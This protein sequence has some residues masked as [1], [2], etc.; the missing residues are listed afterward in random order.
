MKKVIYVFNSAFRPLYLANVLNTLFLPNGSTNEYRY[1]IQNVSPT[2]EETLKPKLPVSIIYIDRFNVGGYC[3][4]PLRLGH[5]VS[6]QIK[7]DRF[8]IKVKLADFVFPKDQNVFGKYTSNLQQQ[9]APMLTNNDPT[10]FKDGYYAF[11]YND[12]FENKDEYLWGDA[13]WDVIIE[14]LSK[15]KAFNLGLAKPVVYLSASIKGGNGKILSP[16]LGRDQ[17]ATFDVVRNKRYTLDLF[18]RFPLQRENTEVIE[19]LEVD[20][21][22][23]FRL[24]DSEVLPINSSSNSVSKLFTT[25]KYPNDSYGKISIKSNKDNVIISDAIIHLRIRETGGYWVEVFF[26]A[27]VFLVCSVLIGLNLS[28]LKYVGISIDN[29]ENGLTTFQ[30]ILESIKHLLFFI[31]TALIQGISVFRM[32]KLLGKNII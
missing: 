12:I 30:V 32:F 25:E 18:Y 28:D 3:Y 14:K 15:T 22:T 31:I 16:S 13:A 1:S 24:I 8:Y 21:D 4:F 2:L 6:Y 27:F 7:H 19:N 10:T 29:I 5:L 11:N 20:T 26:W 17:I 9:N 23:P